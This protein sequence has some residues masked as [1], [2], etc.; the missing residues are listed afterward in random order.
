MSGPRIVI[1]G[2]G[3]WVFPLELSRDILAFPALQACTLV[4]YDIDRAAAERTESFVRQLVSDAGL[5]A[6]VEVAP[7]LRAALRGADVVL[8][9]FQVG[10][11]EAY[12]LDVEIPRSYGVDQTVGDTLGPGGVFRG[13]RTVEALREVAEAMLEI[14]PDAWLLNYANPMAIN[15]WAVDRLGVRIVGLCHSVQSTS[16]Q[17]A[18]ELGVPYEEVTFECAGVNHTAWF[19]TFRRGEEDLIPKIREVMKARHVDRTIPLLPRSDD[20]YESI[21]R[22]RAELMLLTGYFHTESSH[23]ASEYWAW[24]RRTPELTASYLDRRWDYLEVCRSSDASTTN[25]AIVEEARREGLRH[26]GEFAAPIID[27]LVTGT[28]RVVYGNVR[29]GGSIENLPADACVEI[30]CAVD[31]NGVRPLRYGSLPPACAAL[32]QVQINVQRLAV[33]AAMTGDRNLVHAAVALDPLTSAVL[34][35]P[36][37]HEMVDRMLEAE[38]RWLPRFRR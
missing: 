14:C 20:P 36:E 37:I 12:A 31:A 3:G 2:A 7:D 11:V 25:E 19:T 38:A 24:F 9:V 13:L 26:G 5:P 29:N 1:V 4:L 18:R 10:G 8:T 21:E 15:C 6:R 28:P 30:A 34:T 32:N 33:E 22:V 27:S 35:L 17:L 16:R 23:H